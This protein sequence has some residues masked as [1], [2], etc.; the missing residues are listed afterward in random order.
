MK[1]LVPIYYYDAGYSDTVSGLTLTMS[2]ELTGYESYKAFTTDDREYM[3]YTGNLYMSNAFTTSGIQGLVVVS[4]E[5]SE[6]DTDRIYL[7][8]SDTLAGTYTAKTISAVYGDSTSGTSYFYPTTSTTGKTKSFAQYSTADTSYK[9]YRI[10][11]QHTSSQRFQNITHGY[12]YDLPDGYRIED[13]NFNYTYKNSIV[14]TNLVGNIYWDGLQNNSIKKSH[15]LTFEYLT[16][17]QKETLLDIFKLGRG[18]LPVWFIEDETDNN[19][20]M[21]AGMKTMTVSEPYVDYYKVTI[22]LVEY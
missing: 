13:Q 20:W 8:S 22:N 15:A 11:C 9:Y 12:V 1:I 5:W 16:S 2:D 7:E 3:K 18:G 17:T 21:Y 4:D 19:T 14:K 10:R 6:D